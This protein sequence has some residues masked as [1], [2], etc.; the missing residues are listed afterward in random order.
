MKAW[1]DAC[2]VLVDE[3]RERDELHV[4]EHV[5]L[6][7]LDGFAPTHS[8]ASTRAVGLPRNLPRGPWG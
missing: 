5:D 2:C 4:D 6:L 8:G 1:H 7:A 3:R